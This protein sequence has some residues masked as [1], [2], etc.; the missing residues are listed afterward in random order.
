ME[1]KEWKFNCPTCKSE[2]R[3]AQSVVDEDKAEGRLGANVEVGCT[4]IHE[5]PLTDP[6]KKP[7]VGDQLSVVVFIHDVCADCGTE[8]IFKV[9][10]EIR[11]LKLD[12][13]GIINP[14][15]GGMQR[16]PQLPPNFNKG[17]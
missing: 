5:V 11:T 4:S 2:S 6:A 1:N 8:Y 14:R 10:R 16:I 7:G 17:N 12:V 9:V 15:H 13:S 3:I